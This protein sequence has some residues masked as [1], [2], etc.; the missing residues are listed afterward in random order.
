MYDVILLCLAFWFIS[1]FLLPPHLLGLYFPFKSFFQQQCCNI[2]H[3]RHK[4]MPLSVRHATLLCA[5]CRRLHH[6]LPDL[7]TTD[8]R[9]PGVCYRRSWRACELALTHGTCL[10]ANRLQLA[11]VA[12]MLWL[13]WPCC[14]VLSKRRISIT[15]I[16]VSVFSATRH[17]PQRPT[18]SAIQATYCLP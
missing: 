3:Y 15:I 10:I 5:V 13:S 1:S 14:C 18:Y 4:K 16:L 8:C 9:K 7:Y 2:M 11:V 6:R 17:G 12:V